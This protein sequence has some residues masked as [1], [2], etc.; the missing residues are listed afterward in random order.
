ME[1]LDETWT[2]YDGQ[3]YYADWEEDQGS[4]VEVM[5]YLPGVWQL[6]AGGSAEYF[7]GNQIG[8]TRMMTDSSTPYP[9]ITRQ[10]VYTAF[11]ELTWTAAGSTDTRYGYAG[12]FGYE[13]GLLP[14]RGT[15]PW[16]YMRS[17]G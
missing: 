8:T 14:I 10:A 1:V 15:P 16:G 13:E 12:A 9:Q 4:P 7:H 6:E 3:E 17:H 2:D 11:G 5:G